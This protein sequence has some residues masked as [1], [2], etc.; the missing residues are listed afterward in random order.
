MESELKRL[1]LSEFLRKEK[2]A[3]KLGAVDLERER[4]LI[5]M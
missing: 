5:N 3:G 4:P 1:G 2:E